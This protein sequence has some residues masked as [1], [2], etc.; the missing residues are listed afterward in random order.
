MTALK[1]ITKKNW[2][3]KKSI[4]VFFKRVFFDFFD[5]KKTTVV[6]LYGRILTD[7]E[8]LSNDENKIKHEIRNLR[9][10]ISN[11]LIVVKNSFDFINNVIEQFK[12]NIK[13]ILATTVEKILVIDEVYMFYSDLNKS[14]FDVFKTIVIDTIVAE[15]QNVLDDNR[16][17][18]LLKYESQIM[19]MFQ[20]VNFD[21]TKRFQ[22]S[23]VFWFE[24]FS[25]NELQ[26]I[27]LF[28]FAIQNL[29]ATSQIIFTIIDILNPLW[30]E[31]NFDN[32]DD[33]KNLISKIKTNYRVWQ[34]ALSTTQKSIDFIFESQN[35]DSHYNRAFNAK[36]NF[37]KL[38]QK[39]MSCEDIV[40]KLN[41]FL[42]VVKKMRAQ[43]FE[44]REQISMNFIFKRSFDN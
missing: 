14:N 4:N 15:V 19:K 44:P 36:I 1:R 39:V 13:A 27:L 18:L 35:F 25:Y 34:S 3:K 33:V 28:K 20:N 38:F 41:E 16:C 40:S 5:T 32:D 8:M 37:E 17:V 10:L 21:F 43:G 11:V 6:K 2:K 7:I 30:N 22:L 23:N 9:L 12:I 42:K 24:N 26:K 29:K 31:L